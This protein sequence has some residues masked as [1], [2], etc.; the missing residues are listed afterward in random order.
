MVVGFVLLAALGVPAPAT[1][2]V[3]F[4]TDVS[5][6]DGLFTLEVTRA[7]APKGVDHFRFLLEDGFFNQVKNVEAHTP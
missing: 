1:F 6:G 2:L 5:P 4:R 3:D 7:W